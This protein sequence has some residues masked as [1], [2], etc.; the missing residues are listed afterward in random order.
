MSPISILSLMCNLGCAI[1]NA[2]LRPKAFVIS[3]IIGLITGLGIGFRYYL[4]AVKI[5]LNQKLKKKIDDRTMP[6]QVKVISSKDKFFLTPFGK[7]IEKVLQL[8]WPFIKTGIIVSGHQ[9]TYDQASKLLG[10][11]QSQRQEIL[12]NLDPVPG[13]IGTTIS[14]TTLVMNLFYLAKPLFFYLASISG[15]PMGYATGLF[16]M[17]RWT[18]SLNND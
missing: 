10:N 15:Y 4:E 2:Y 9:R 18:L 8:A 1:G 12:R 6:L 5:N 16:I 3:Y 14:A 7:L 13:L 17:Q 11:F